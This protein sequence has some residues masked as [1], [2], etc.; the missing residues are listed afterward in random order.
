MGFEALAIEAKRPIGSLDLSK[1]GNGLKPLPMA[2][3]SHY[4]RWKV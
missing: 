1:D 2:R 4:V 3:A